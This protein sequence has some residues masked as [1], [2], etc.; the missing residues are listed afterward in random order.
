MNDK[1]LITKRFEET[2]VTNFNESLRLE[3]LQPLN[4]QTRLH[5]KVIA[6]LKELQRPHD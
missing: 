6:R 1:E 2:K 5:P 4:E 3:G